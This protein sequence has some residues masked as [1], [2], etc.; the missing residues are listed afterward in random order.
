MIRA[1]PS[2]EYINHAT[3]QTVTPAIPTWCSYLRTI[4]ATVFYLR[5]NQIVYQRQ[6][7]GRRC[8]C[9]R[10]EKENCT[11]KAGYLLSGHIYHISQH[12]P[13]KIN[14]M[15]VQY[16]THK[17]F[18]ISLCI[19]PHPALFPFCLLY[20]HTVFTC[21]WNSHPC[22]SFAPPRH[23]K[24]YLQMDKEDLQDLLIT[25]IPP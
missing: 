11:R 8:V 18:L 3:I 21:I 2:L 1:L 25:G 10:Q 15:P 16:A 5:T 24:S 9:W 17:I 22:L 19:N 7:K 23:G 12:L 13:Q 6:W 4:P 20:C 14:D